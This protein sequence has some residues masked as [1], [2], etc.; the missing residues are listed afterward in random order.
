MRR[1]GGTR[2]SGTTDPTGSVNST[3]STS[4]TGPDRHPSPA[5]VVA[6]VNG[7]TASI[8]GTYVVTSSVLL[9]ALAGV[10]AVV[11]ATVVVALHLRSGR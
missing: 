2:H 3:D 11:V 7:V 9:A 4:P 5:E 1:N 10:L 8:A 6:L